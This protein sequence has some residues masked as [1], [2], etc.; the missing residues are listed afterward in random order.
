M[1]AG[2]GGESALVAHRGFVAREGVCTAV[3]ADHEFRFFALEYLV[4]VVFVVLVF[5]VVVFVIR[6]LITALKV[7]QRICV[8]LPGG[9][10]VF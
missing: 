8:G 2:C 5:V 3:D 7:V 10:I 6:L 4:F 9:V 1:D